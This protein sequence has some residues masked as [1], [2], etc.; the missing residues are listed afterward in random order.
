[1]TFTAHS[2]NRTLNLTGAVNGGNYV[3]WFKQDGTG[4]E[5]LVLGSGCT[6]KVSGSGSGAVTLSTG[7]NAIDVL[8][9][10]YD[11]TNCYAN[12]AKNFN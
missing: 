1:L 11:G 5:G 8:A 9:F 2:G 6:W 12:F 7:A 4:G 3:V 10:T